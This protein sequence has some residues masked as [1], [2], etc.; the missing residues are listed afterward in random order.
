MGLLEPKEFGEVTARGIQEDSNA[1]VNAIGLKSHIGHLTVFKLDNGL[2]TVKKL[3]GAQGGKEAKGLIEQVEGPHHR[4]A[5]RNV[6]AIHLFYQDR[7]RDVD[8][9]VLLRY[10]DVFIG[11]LSV[12]TFGSYRESG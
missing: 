1:F 4:H 9:E 2:A 11:S 6:H 7:L 3:L 10:S 5:P 12:S 8:V